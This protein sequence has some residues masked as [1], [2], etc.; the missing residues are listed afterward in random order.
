M[1]MLSSCI[2]DTPN[3]W[4][5]S[6]PGCGA[7]AQQTMR[8][9]PRPNPLHPPFEPSGPPGFPSAMK[10]SQTPVSSISILQAKTHRVFPTRTTPPLFRCCPNPAFRIRE[11]GAPLNEGWPRGS[12][13][14]TTDNQTASSRTTPN[15]QPREPLRWRH[16]AV[17]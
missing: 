5:A 4:S 6:Q 11:T 16:V 2:D 13:I 1:I 10:T 3:S 15:M 8:W 7:M 9:V 14:R 17:T 12:R